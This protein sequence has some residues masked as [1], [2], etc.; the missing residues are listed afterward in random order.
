MIH[1]NA[2]RL[3]DIYLENGSSILNKHKNNCDLF[4]IKYEVTDPSRLIVLVKCHE[5]YS[6][7]VGQLVSIQFENYKPGQQKRDTLKPLGDDV[8]VRCTCPSFHFW[9]PH[10]NATEEDYNLDLPEHRKPDIRDPHR[11]NKLCKHLIN[12]AEFLKHKTFKQLIKNYT[13]GESYKKPDSYNKK[14]R[15]KKKSSLQED[16]ELINQLPKVNLK[17]ITPTITDYLLRVGVK[18]KE[19]K[20]VINNMNET[21]FEEVLLKYGVIV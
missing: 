6:N 2:K 13:P 14:R 7:Q 5:S 15:F 3:L 11:H 4:Q 21:N 16:R 9:G 19:I 17:D 1:L 10:Y 8:K 20:K 12:V 18:N